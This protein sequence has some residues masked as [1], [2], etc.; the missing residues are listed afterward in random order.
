MSER[1]VGIDLGTTNSVVAFVND[2]GV[3]EAIPDEEGARITPSAVQLVADGDPIVGALARQ[4]AVVEPHRVAQAFKRGMGER[5]FLRDERPFVVDGKTWSP[6]E[7][8]ALVLKK[9][10]QTAERHFGQPV[11]KAVIT[12][13]AYFGD[14]E[15]KA[16]IAAGEIAGLDVLSIIN[17]PTA[18]A[19]AH[20]LDSGTDTGLILVFDLGGGTFDVTVME[21]KAGEPLTVRSTGGDH[22]FGGVD[23]DQLILDRMDE[24]VRAQAGSGLADDPYA[25]QDA[26]A[27]AEE[28]K[29]ELSTKT[30]ATRPLTGAGRPVMFTLTR[31]EFELMLSEHLAEIDDHVLHA[32]EKAGVAAQQ[33]DTVLMVGGSSRIPSFRERLQQLTGKEPRF[34]KNLDEDV[35][36]GAALMAAKA[37]N[38]ADPRSQLARMPTPVDVASHGLGITTQRDY[39]RSNLYNSLLIPA[40]TPVPARREEVFSTV[41]DGQRQLQLTLNEGD[42]DDLDLVRELGESVGN[43]N[44]PVQRD[45]PV[46]V[47][48]EYTDQQ[49]IRASAFDGQTDEF[50]C[51]IEV[52]S[53]GVISDEAKRQAM[54]YLSKVEVG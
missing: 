45:H 50:L 30:S 20:G 49:L 11:S 41:Y 24:T 29:K 23:F 13:P 47:V 35:A 15:R 43:F 21:A 40:G 53:A 34:S 22:Q 48:V 17:E 10:R 1:V 38:T 18:A 19:I 46:R 33:I 14:A 31:A 2:A 4:M 9:L 37:S 25:L 7:L 42:S 16:T 51:E 32:I 52:R 27:K 8:S 26:R 3:A 39:N 54:R 28:I 36:R 44:R 6:E 12:V 5:T